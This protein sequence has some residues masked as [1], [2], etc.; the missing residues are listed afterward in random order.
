MPTSNEEALVI[1]AAVCGVA[2]AFAAVRGWL[3]RRRRLAFR[4][5]AARA[6][7]DPGDGPWVDAQVGA[8]RIVGREI[9]VRHARRDPEKHTVISAEL[10]GTFPDAFHASTSAHAIGLL[11]R[12]IPTPSGRHQVYVRGPFAEEV[13]ALLTEPIVAALAEG[14]DLAP[15]AVLEPGVVR[16]SQMRWFP[17]EV[18]VRSFAGIARIARAFAPADAGYRAA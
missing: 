14:L 13:D 15:D 7:L 9:L 5:A 17:P 12:T 3:H 4:D 1:T 8:T 18:L 16:L 10:P 6:G 11:R 2:G